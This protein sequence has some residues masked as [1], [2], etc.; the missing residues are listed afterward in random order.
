MPENKDS[1]VG[2]IHELPLPCI[3]LRKSYLDLGL[4]NH[5]SKIQNRYDALPSQ[6]FTVSS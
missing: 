6:D 3:V 4:V 2:A 5:Q 1:H